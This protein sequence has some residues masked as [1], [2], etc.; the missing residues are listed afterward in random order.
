[1]SQKLYKHSRYEKRK[2][3]RFKVRWTISD[4]NRYQEQK[5]YRMYDPEYFGTGKPLFLNFD[6]D[7][8]L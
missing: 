1:M 3:M 4:L 6:L 7:M 2:S 5:N 8:A